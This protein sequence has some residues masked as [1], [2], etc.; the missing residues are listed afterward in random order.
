[1]R[2]N[3]QHVEN[4]SSVKLD[5]RVFVFPSFAAT[6]CFVGADCGKSRVEERIIYTIREPEI[7]VRKFS[8]RD[9][10]VSQTSVA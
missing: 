4:E 7:R 5:K 9:S 2:N 3:V 8:L 10:I 1:M 6:R